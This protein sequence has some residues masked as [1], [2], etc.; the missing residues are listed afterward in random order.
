MSDIVLAFNREIAEKF[1][2][3]D[4]AV[5]YNHILF[6]L[7]HNQKKGS[8]QKNGKTWT[9]QSCK[10]IADHLGYLDHQAVK[11]CLVKLVDSGY[12]IRDYLSENKFEKTA[13]YTIPDDSNK[14]YEG[15][16]ENLP[17]VKKE[18]S[19]PYILKEEQEEEH[20]QEREKNLKISHGSHVKLPNE[21]YETLCT[22]NPKS[23]I[24]DIINQMNDYCLAH[25]KSYKDYAAA[26]RQWLK[27]RTE[28]P[29]GARNF[30]QVDR[31][32]KNKDG[33]PAINPYEGLF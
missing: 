15:S 14:F 19:T 21:Q 1:K 24:D 18:P 31:R 28:T 4:V 2:S 16:K 9:Y 33:T 11:K 13:W 30:N 20:T 32:T 17:R 10:E 6:W 7:R 29:Q 23:I 12:L 25:G 8:A 26:I 22:E 27:K 5:V 3:A